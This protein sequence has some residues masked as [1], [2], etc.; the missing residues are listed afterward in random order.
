[1]VILVSMI[2]DNHLLDIA[3]G[4]SY[5]SSYLALWIVRTIYKMYFKD[6]GIEDQ[7]I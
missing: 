1:M 3:L 2:C 7:T 6:E 4:I 5:M